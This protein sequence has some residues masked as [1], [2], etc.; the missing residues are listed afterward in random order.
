MSNRQRVGRH[1]RRPSTAARILTALTLAVLAAASGVVGVRL[2]DGIRVGRS[3]DT[4][5]VPI[6]ASTT[7]PPT[8]PGSGGRSSSPAATP[9]PPARTPPPPGVPVKLALPS[10]R[11]SA[12]VIPAGTR[13]DGQLRL[14]RSPSVVGWWVRSAPA[15]DRRDTTMLAGHVDS[16]AEGVGALA[17]LREIDVG[18]RVVLTDTFGVEHSYRVAARRVYPKYALP[19][20]IFTVTGRARVVLI[21]CGGPFDEEAGRYR[22][23]V[24]VY[25]LPS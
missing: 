21:T 8:R 5:D 23:N 2:L 7:G 25:A 1:R 9:R 10:E 15:G 16:A 12:P 3:P 18:S 11:V 19:D 4:G 22:D 17:A 6:A 14:P 24:V 13:P 20:D